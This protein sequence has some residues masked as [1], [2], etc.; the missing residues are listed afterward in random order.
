M[1]FE[2]RTLRTQRLLRSHL[3][4]I[5]RVEFD[6]DGET[7]SRDVVRHPGAV[8]VLA[9]DGT[10]VILVRQWRAPLTMPILEI[11]AGTC[12]QP[13]E[14]TEATARRELEEEAGIF[15]GHLERL[16]TIWNAPGWS[17]Q[18]TEVFLA[19]ELRDVPRRPSGPEEDAIEVVRLQLGDALALLEEDQP[20]D[21]TTAVGLRA[22]AAWVAR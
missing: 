15:A 6:D 8:A 18:R 20:I 7:F 10:H 22:L 16:C 5:E 1:G 9:F 2:P 4:E 14:T 13:G 11:P 21:A 3:F 17:D 19:T 12:D